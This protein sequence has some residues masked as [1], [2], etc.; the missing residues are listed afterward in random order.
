M[1]RRRPERRLRRKCDPSRRQGA[2]VQA[3]F[4]RGRN[5]LAQGPEGQE[6]RPLLLPEG[7]HPPGC[8]REAC[9]FRDSQA[10]IKKTGAVVLGVSPDSL[11]A[12]EQVP[13]E[14]QARTSRCCPIPTRRSPG[15]YGAWGEKVLYGKKTVGMIRS[16][17]VIDGRG[18]RAEG[19]PAR[20][21]RRPRRAGAGRAREAL[22]RAAMTPPMPAGSRAWKRCSPSGAGASRARCASTPCFEDA[23]SVAR[24]AADA[25]Y[26]PA[27]RLRPI[28]ALLVADVFRAPRRGAAARRRA[29]S[30]WSTPPA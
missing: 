27:K 7:R 21:G 26:A 1:P 2:R 29:R 10:E 18:S 3:S 28:L 12:H 9:A 4:R 30:S 5:G 13:R 8:T 24:A 19:V 16:T 20:Q 17:F 11:A 23:G 14:V 6:R 15:K 22:T 25:L